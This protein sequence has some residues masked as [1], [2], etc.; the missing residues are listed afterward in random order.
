MLI[1]PGDA[2][3]CRINAHRH[4][5]N[6]DI[7]SNPASWNCGNPATN[8]RE[9]VC[10]MGN[11]K[12]IHL[13]IF[14]TNTPKFITPDRTVITLLTE[15]P[16]ILHDQLLFFYGPRFNL[17]SGIIPGDE[18]FYGAYRVNNSYLDTWNDQV[19]IEPYPEDWV[20]FPHNLVRRPYTQV[21]EGINYFKS[22]NAAVTLDLVREA[23]KLTRDDTTWT[24]AQKTRLERFVESLEGWQDAARKRMQHEAKYAPNLAPANNFRKEQSFDSPF[25]KLNELKIVREPFIENKASDTINTSLPAGS[26]VDGSTSNIENAIFS[27]GKEENSETI[28]TTVLDEE[29]KKLQSGFKTLRTALPEESQ[30]V[31]IASKFGERMVKALQVASSS[32]TLIILTGPPGAGKSWMASRLIDDPMRERSII[33][34]VSSTWRGREDLLGYV[35]PVSNSFVPTAFTRFLLRAQDAWQEGD[36]R[37]WLVI[38]EEFNLS[39]PEHWLSDLLVRLEFDSEQMH[40]RTIDLGASLLIGEKGLPGSS[41]VFLPQNLMFVATINNDHT[42]RPLSARIL[43]R[44]ALLEVSAS[45]KEALKRA[46][47]E[48]VQ[49]IEDIVQDLNFRIE[50]HGVAFSVRSARSLLRASQALEQADM[51]NMLDH[52]I[53]QGVLS[54]LRLHKDDPGDEKLLERLQDWIARPVCAPLL[55]CSERIAAWDDALR[56]GRDIF[57]A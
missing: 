32:K 46:G 20:I 24:V 49:G 40:D 48:S 51:M 16:E 55:L 23:L 11:P 12:C 18:F 6:G 5:W 42:V 57:Q 25:A 2:F 45:G 53:V 33:V 54:K 34:P 8:F 28:L 19:I 41:S 35:N 27:H 43:D 15:R 7:C 47:L 22:I 37:V 36:R 9:N 44:A 14:S 17:S 13:N 56:A 29:R 30:I 21:I 10:G 26:A 4:Q 39:Q 50:S 52:I 1:E 38:F 3:A 31:E